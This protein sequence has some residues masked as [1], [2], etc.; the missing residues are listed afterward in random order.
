MKSNEM[1]YCWPKSVI[2]A[3]IDWSLSNEACQFAFERQMVGF[4][5]IKR[6]PIARCMRSIR[7][8]RAKVSPGLLQCKV[9]NR[10]PTILRSDH[11]SAVDVQ[12]FA[13]CKGGV[14]ACEVD[15]GGGELERLAGALDGSVRTE[16]GYFLRGKAGWD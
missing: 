6:K 11:S 2:M 8:T 4:I 14:V 1:A 3:M 13:C 16:D 10:L 5:P 15:V 12:Y 7:L 9:L